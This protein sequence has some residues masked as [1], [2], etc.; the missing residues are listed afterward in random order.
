MSFFLETYF[1]VS[2]SPRFGLLY[3]CTFSHSIYLFLFFY[4]KQCWLSDFFANSLAPLQEWI[5]LTE[6]SHCGFGESPTQEISSLQLQC[7]IIWYMQLLGSNFVEPLP[8]VCRPECTSMLEQE[9]LDLPC[10]LINTLP[11]L[12][13]HT[14]AVLLLTWLQFFTRFPPS[15]VLSLSLATIATMRS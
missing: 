9:A 5:N 14:P 12:A 2:T 11:M 13:H 10:F 7:K 3:N 4:Y 15:L 8:L 1:T 6:T